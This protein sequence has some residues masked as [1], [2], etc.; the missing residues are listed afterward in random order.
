[1]SYQEQNYGQQNGVGFVQAIV[2][3]AIALF[4]G[5]KNI[6][7]KRKRDKYTDRVELWSEIIADFLNTPSMTGKTLGDK[8]WSRFPYSDEEDAKS[9]K[10]ISYY[11]REQTFNWLVEKLNNAL[12]ALD[13]APIEKADIIAQFNAANQQ[14]A[15]QATTNPMVLT[16]QSSGKTVLPTT[17][18]IAPGT[19]APATASIGGNNTLMMVGVAAA[20][21]AMVYI[22]GKA[23]KPASLSGTKKR[24]APRRKKKS[25]K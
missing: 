19:Q 6:L 7:G 3:A 11:N 14:V 24:K 13:A 4:Q 23:D 12:D 17:K 9:R 5:I 21:G 18:D 16:S 10:K 1:M 20:L 22:G 2:P 25:S 15:N 8:Y